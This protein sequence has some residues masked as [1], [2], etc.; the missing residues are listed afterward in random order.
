[1]KYK[2]TKKVILLS[3]KEQFFEQILNKTKEY[4]FRKQFPNESLTAVVYLSFPVM[5]IVGIIEFDKPIIFDISLM[6]EHP[7]ISPYNSASLIK[8]YSGRETGY[9]IPVLDVYRLEKAISLAE[10][11]NKQPDFQPPQSYSYLKYDS[12]L[13]DELIEI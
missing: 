9:A 13:F 1:M 4:E 7:L 2:T 11:R 6:K 3:L 8:Y 12:Y 5:K 10:I